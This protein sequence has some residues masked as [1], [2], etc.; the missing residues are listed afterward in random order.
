MVSTSG[1]TE[2]KGGHTAGNPIPHRSLAPLCGHGSHCRPRAAQPRYDGAFMQVHDQNLALARVKEQVPPRCR[3]TL[4]RDKHSQAADVSVAQRRPKVGERIGARGRVPHAHAPVV[5]RRDKVRT[6]VGPGKAVDG[7]GVGFG[8]HADAAANDGGGGGV[9]G[10]W[11]GQ[12][13]RVEDAEAVF[14]VEE[15]D[16]GVGAPDVPDADGA[17][18]GAAGEDVFV[19][20]RP[21][22][23]EDG[24]GGAAG[25][26]GGEEGLDRG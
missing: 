7:A 20:G 17:V 8:G 15:A 26:A 5:A 24:A 4:G 13:A 11:G 12:T 23:G 3:Q 22:D 9:G 10:V 6:A 1:K 19:D 2:E 21:G 25:L 18:G 16:E 14:L